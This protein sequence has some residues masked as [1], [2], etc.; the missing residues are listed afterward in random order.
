MLGAAQ[1]PYAASKFAI[2]LNIRPAI[3]GIIAD[4]RN[5]RSF[6]EFFGQYEAVSTE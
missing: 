5:Q 1:F 3:S 6:C 4:P 2:L